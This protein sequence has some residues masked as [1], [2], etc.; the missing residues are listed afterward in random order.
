MKVRGNNIILFY[1]KNGEWKT[2]AYGS[3]CEIDINAGTINVSSPDTGKWVSRK[4]RK[5]DWSINAAY[6]FFMSCPPFSSDME[7]GFSNPQTPI[8]L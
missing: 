3:T 8:L 7:D 4:K 6:L 1:Q 2:I 5:L